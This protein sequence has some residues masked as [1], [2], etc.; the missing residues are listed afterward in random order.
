VTDPQQPKSAYLK[1]ASTLHAETVYPKQR[2]ILFSGDVAILFSVSGSR[3][4]RAGADHLMS[5]PP[6][7]SNRPSSSSREIKS[8]SADLH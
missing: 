7:V 5:S 8:L 6:L 4:G 1:F 2:F 3:G